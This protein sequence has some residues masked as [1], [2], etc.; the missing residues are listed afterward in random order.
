VFQFGQLNVKRCV[1][2]RSMYVKKRTVAPHATCKKSSKYFHLG[3]NHFLSF[4]QFLTYDICLPVYMSHLNRIN[5]EST[6]LSIKLDVFE[7]KLAS[8][9]WKNVKI[10][11]PPFFSDFLGWKY[12]LET[13]LARIFRK[14]FIFLFFLVEIHSSWIEIRKANLNH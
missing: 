9:S 10:L 2:P 5:L 1:S 14:I 11:S 8:H 7:L 4:E 3:R 13:F 12:T 6:L